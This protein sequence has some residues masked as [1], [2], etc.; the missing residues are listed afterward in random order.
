MVI[1]DTAHLP[2]YDADIILNHG[3]DAQRLTYNCASDTL[4]LLGT[5]FALLRPEFQRWHGVVRHCPEVARKLVVTLGGSDAENTTL[6][7]IEAL[8]Q[9]STP[10]LEIKVVVG[11]LNPHLAE[12]QHAIASL[13]LR[14]YLELR[15]PIGV[16]VLTVSCCVCQRIL[17]AGSWACVLLWPFRLRRTLL[18]TTLFSAPASRSLKRRDRWSRWVLVLA[19]LFTVAQRR[20][21]CRRSVKLMAG[22]SSSKLSGEL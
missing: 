1:D 6:K 13:S 10:D 17:P 8:E 19:F 3:L 15:Q 14:V 2:R 20:V 4:F 22:G 9:I 18:Q 21:L 12:L 7:I 5:R 16:E 11:P